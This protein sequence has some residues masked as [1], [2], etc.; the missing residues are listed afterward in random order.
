MLLDDGQVQERVARVEALLEQLESLPDAS[1]RAT[2]TETVQLLLD[3][4]GEGLGRMMD[5]VYE[6]GGAP[7]LESLADDE[8]VSHLMLL[9]GLHPIALETRVLRALQGVRPYLE[10]HGGNVELVHRGPAA[11]RVWRA[12]ARVARPPR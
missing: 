1:A 10:S 3:L 8:L 4:Y 11:Y 2:A 7:M 5:S 6:L 9:H 12:V